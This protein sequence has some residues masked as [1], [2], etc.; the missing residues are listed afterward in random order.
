MGFTRTPGAPAVFA[1]DF[2]FR[3]GG[4]DYDAFSALPDV[5][6]AAKRCVDSKTCAGDAD[7]GAIWRDSVD[8]HFYLAGSEPR[9]SI[10]PVRI[11]QTF[12]EQVDGQPLSDYVGL[13]IHYKIGWE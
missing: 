2:N 3:P 6:N 10:E 5:S 11:E 4:A 9:I 1:A 12:K 8:H 13:E 7:P